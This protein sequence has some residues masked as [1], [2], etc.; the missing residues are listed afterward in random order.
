MFDPS[1]FIL[2]LVYLIR[3]PITRS[4]KYEI[5]WIYLTLTL[6]KML[7]RLKF[8]KG[9]NKIKILDFIIDYAD[10]KSFYDLFCEIFLHN[11]YFF[12]SNKKTPLIVDCGSNIGLTVIYFK[13]LY[14]QAKIL[15]FEPDEEAL[16]L[17]K[18]NIRQ[19]SL[20]NIKIF[21]IALASRK[22]KAKFYIAKGIGAS[23]V[24]GFFVYKYVKNIIEK[25]VKTDTLSKFIQEE[26]DFLKMDVEGA[27]T[28]IIEELNSSG[29]IRNINQ[30]VV[31]FHLSYFYKKPDFS[32]F[33]KVLED[34]KM[35]H[36]F[37]AIAVP[38]FQLTKV[39]NLMIFARKKTEQAI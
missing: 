31:E 32:R 21:P 20:K 26:V 22:G 23:A 15:C 36:H 14:P 18:N 19:N 34:N 39:Q 4:Q 28:Q 11:V 2:D 38:L 7:I 3:A 29:K 35:V 9:Q 1:Y 37:H 17:L 13:Y 8:I 33:L 30:M 25:T 5:F 27:E 6:K 16:G 10:Y 24:S 12:K